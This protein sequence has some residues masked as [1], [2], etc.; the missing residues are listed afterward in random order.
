[1]RSGVCRIGVKEYAADGATEIRH[2]FTDYNLSQAYLDRR[3]IGLVSAS[4]PYERE[5][6]AEQDHLRL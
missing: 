3:I 1:M 5:Q 4:A 6:L 2:T